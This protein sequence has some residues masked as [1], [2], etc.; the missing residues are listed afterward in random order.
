M[1][2]ARGFRT[3]DKEVLEGIG[4]LGFGI[5]Q[6]QLKTLCARECKESGRGKRKEKE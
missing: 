2:R 5:S 6:R 3:G 4:Q 1:T